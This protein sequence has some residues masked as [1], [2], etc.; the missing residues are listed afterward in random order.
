MTVTGT[1]YP[2]GSA[3]EMAAG[4]SAGR[5]GGG[6]RGAGCRVGEVGAKIKRNGKGRNG[7]GEVRFLE[8]YTTKVTDDGL[9]CLQGLTA[10]ENVCRTKNQINDSELVQLPE[11]GRLRHFNLN[12][13]RFTDEELGYRT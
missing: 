2:K 6:A 4:L 1:A 3:H 9:A 13:N 8:L 11:R 5:E 12:R 7:K 10:L